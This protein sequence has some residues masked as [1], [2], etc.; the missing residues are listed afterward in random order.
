MNIINTAVTPTTGI[1]TRP[2]NKKPRVVL[3]FLT[4]KFMPAT[5]WEK[6]LRNTLTQ[7]AGTGLS[8]VTGLLLVPIIIR[9]IGLVDFGMWALASGLVGSLG[10]LDAGLQPTLTKKVAESLALND[11]A[12]LGKTAGR[13]LAMYLLIGI[14]A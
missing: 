9:K 5:S 10:L 8:M 1:T 13:V 2:S 12:G 3:N 7:Y 11:E 4:V 14:L 6:L